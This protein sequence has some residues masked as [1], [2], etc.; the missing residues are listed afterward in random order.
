MISMSTPSGV[1]TTY[2]LAK[3]GNRPFLMRRAF[4]EDAELEML[5]KTDAISFPSSAKG[6]SAI[7]DILVRRFG[8][9]YENV[10]TFCL[11]QPSLAN[12]RHFP[13][14]WLVGMSARNNGQVR[15]GCGRYD[16]YFGP[17]EECRVERL[18][19]AIDVMK[20]LP[21]AD[22][23]ASMNW[24]SSLPY[25]WCTPAE[26]IRDVPTIEGLAEIEAYLKQVR[27]LLPER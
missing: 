19:I 14:H 16:W 15:V 13:C 24:L 5:V 20:V 10:Y 4:A 26:A 3:D 23:A 12:R 17:D 11:S 7:E 9:D 27:R 25:R 18:V 21:A 1:V 2:I 6:V 8:L 22:V